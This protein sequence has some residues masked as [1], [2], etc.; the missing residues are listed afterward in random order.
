MSRR[1]W[2]ICGAAALC[3]ACVAADPQTLFLKSDGGPIGAA[4]G[5]QFQADM[6]ICRAEAAKASV[7]AQDCKGGALYCLEFDA[8][9]QRELSEIKEGC[10]AQKGYR[11]RTPGTRI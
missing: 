9:R 6:T 11:L 5:Q 2:V 10:M 7:G 8:K 3:S 4:D 1:W